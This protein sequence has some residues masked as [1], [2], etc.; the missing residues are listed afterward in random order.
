VIPAGEDHKQLSFQSVNQAMFWV[1]AARPAAGQ[2]FPQGFGFT[3][4]IEGISQA[5]WIS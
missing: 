3:D 1:D 2:V 5:G 4:A